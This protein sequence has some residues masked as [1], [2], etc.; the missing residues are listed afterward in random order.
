MSGCSLRVLSRRQLHRRW[1]DAAPL[2]RK[3]LRPLQGEYCLGGAVAKRAH[4]VAH[5]GIER[6]K[7][8]NRS[9]SMRCSIGPFSGD[10]ERLSTAGPNRPDSLRTAVL[11]G[12]I[13]VHGY[14]V[15]RRRPAARIAVHE[16]EDDLPFPKYGRNHEWRIVQPLSGTFRGLRMRPLRASERQQGTD[17]HAFTEQAFP[18]HRRNVLP[19]DRRLRRATEPPST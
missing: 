2:Q 12:M 3:S 18:S 5:A 15:N 14:Q 8:L 17:E 13:L 4:Y 1:T 9:S 19:K 16:T 7:A 10:L 11:L 6:R